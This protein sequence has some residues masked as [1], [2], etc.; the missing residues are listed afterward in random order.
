MN[1]RLL[2]AALA[3]L[4]LAACTTASEG[5]Y[6]ARLATDMAEIVLTTR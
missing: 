6:W 2:F 5:L 1:R 3:A 4:A